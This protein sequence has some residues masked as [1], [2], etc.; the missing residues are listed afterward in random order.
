MTPKWA[1]KVRLGL[2]LLAKE[3]TE[4][5]A[6]RRT[7]IVR[8]LYA[9]ALFICFAL[10]INSKID[11]SSGVTRNL[12]AGRQMFEFLVIIQLIGVY[13]LLPAMM[14]GVLAAEKERDSLTLLLVTDLG[15]WEIIIQKLLGRLVPMFT[16]LLLALPLMTVAYGLGG[17]SADYVA[18]GVWILLVACFQVAAFS[19][20]WSAIC[21]TTAQAFVASYVMGATFYFA[22]PVL[23]L[24]MG[25]HVD[26]DVAFAFFP[27]FVFIEGSRRGFG[28]VFLRSIPSVFS[29]GLFLVLSRVF[30]VRRAFAKPKD[31]ALGVFRWIDRVMAG[32]N[33][34][35]GGV[36]IVK[37]RSGLPRDEPVA[38]RE[39]NKKALGK[40][41]YLVR[42]LVAV[43][44][45]VVI[46]ILSIAAGKVGR[47]SVSE[48]FAIA[49]FLLWGIAALTIAVKS[50][51]S[52]VAERAQQTMSVLLATPLTGHEII[53][54]KVKGLKRLIWVL[55]VPFLTVFLAEAFWEAGERSSAGFGFSEGLGAFTYLASS[56]LT[57]V[58]YPPMI[59]WAAMWVGLR[60]KGRSRAVVTVV[61]ALFLWCVVPIALIVLLSLVAGVEATRGG[62]AYLWL[63]SPAV[64]IPLTEIP[65]HVGLSSFG[66]VALVPV[67][68]NCLWHGGALF[69]FRYLSLTHADRHLGRM[70]GGGPAAAQKVA[71]LAARA[72]AGARADGAPREA[73]PVRRTE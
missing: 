6:R 1:T 47:S 3:L 73:D 41:N 52:I 57:L 24:L 22:L 35:T 54:Q 13:A 65:E 34:I 72:R 61:M 66:G 2:P 36:L 56:I 14:A 37:D 20:M 59:G 5:A 40:L 26:D 21:R 12:G 23:G 30:L 7:Y 46:L 62:L 31:M 48:P 18:A 68:L 63:M 42:V 29:A 15:P 49:V 25:A 70:E 11:Y 28:E 44:V 53:K 45:P 8:A 64:I 19:L 69:F 9:A 17:M 60:A 71:E 10:Y 16:F 50:A 67:A 55:W 33:R 51:S 4:L 58:I 39:V 32:A 27:L 43:E 38:W